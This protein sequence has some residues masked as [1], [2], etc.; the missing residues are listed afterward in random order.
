M[1]LPEDSTTSSASTNA[2]RRAS[3]TSAASA[4]SPYP[5]SPLPNSDLSEAPSTPP[6]QAEQSATTASPAHQRDLHQRKRRRRSEAIPPMNFNNPD[7][8]FLSSSPV[9]GSSVAGSDDTTVQVDDTADGD[10][11]SVFEDDAVAVEEGESTVMDLDVDDPTSQSVNSARS[12]GSSGASTGSSGKLEEALR[13][14]AKQAGTQGIEY[15]EHGDLTMDM[16]DDEVTAAF[17]PWVKQGIYLPQVIANLSSLQGQEN[18]NPFSPAFKASITPKQSPRQNS[19]SLDDEETSMDITRA[20]GGILAAQVPS[21]DSQQHPVGHRGRRSSVSR[22][23][24]SGQGSSLGD[25]TMDFTVAVGG[26][27]ASD[28]SEDQLEEASNVD[29]DEELTMEFTVGLGGL[30]SENQK[31]GQSRRNSARDDQL[32]TQQLLNGERRR[33][34]GSSIIGGDQMDMTEVVGGILPEIEETSETPR[35]E[36]EHE[37]VAMDIT[38][39]IGAILPKQLSAG[40]RSQAKALMERET[41]A[42]Q[43][44]PFQVERAL[45]LPPRS[46]LSTHL[47]TV[48]SETGSPSLTTA[49]TRASTRKS[50]GSA[51]STPRRVSRQTTPTKKPATPSKQVTPVAPRPTTPGKTPPNK[52]VTFRAASPK[53]L[54]KAEIKS[55]HSTPH[56]S[57]PKDLFQHN[58]KTGMTTPSILLTPKPRILSGLGIDKPGLGSPRVAAILNRR[59]SIGEQAET[60]TPLNQ[61]GK[62]VRFDDPRIMEQ[63]VE[64]E[65]EEQQRRE[66]GRVILEQEVDG[67]GNLEEKDVT[68]NLKEMIESLTPKKK[69]LHGRKSL[70]VGAA[71]GILGKRPAEL[72]EDDDDENGTPKVLKGREGSPVKNVKL[73]G[74]PPKVETTGKVSRAVRKSLDQITANI[75]TTTPS[76]A[77]SPAEQR[78]VT[79]KNQGRFKDVEPAQ[80]EIPIPFAEK[81]TAEV[82]EAVEPVEEEQRIHLQDFLNLTSIRFMELTTTKRRHTVAP[83]LLLEDKASNASSTVED[84]KSGRDLESCVVAAACT[85]PMLDLFQHVS[86]CP[87]AR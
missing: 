60:F 85:V 14:A 23:R 68:V 46:T 24:S 9:S 45:A 39:A 64:M 11:S 83:N 21:S 72:D 66:S 49:R 30:L 38:T 86:H 36:Q 75:G 35:V 22:R 65:R 84:G 3:S 5:L 41:D 8:E 82:Q 4:A 10:D 29:R 74:P 20:V 1:E 26:I 78:N 61:A 6:E 55:A 15:D 80:A 12:I 67:H 70:H 17:Q 62:G 56:S 79:P 25:E 27:K 63:E 43:L 50:V 54:F 81:L 44:S 59:G 87:R 37:T 33:E 42:G 47:T 77:V 28:Q 48:A 13:Q 69:K 18:I 73:P 31:S 40:N 57:K 58:A 76:T 71:K 52:N 51:Q 7:D 53:K 2:T 16:A 19:H 32:A 34:S